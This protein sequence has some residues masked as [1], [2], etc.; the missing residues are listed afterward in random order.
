MYELKDHLTQMAQYNYWANKKICGFIA[1]AGDERA[2]QIQLSSF[3]SIK[4]TLFHIWDAESIWAE[5]IN[6]FSPDT[7]PSKNFTG[8][9]NEAASGLLATSE[10][11]IEFT[12]KLANEDLGIIINYSN[13]KGEQY[14]NSLSEIISHVMN[15]STFHRGQLV[16]MLRGS[17]F[18][19]LGS[20]DLIAYFREKATIPH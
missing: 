16:T 17:G 11:F 10:R 14:A 1:A 4:K 12:E 20:T 13:I 18:T 7:W 3:N 6:G 9:L 5:R 15:H 8:T 19:E 2:N